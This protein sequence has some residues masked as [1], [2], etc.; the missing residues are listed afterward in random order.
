MLLCAIIVHVM[1]HV[2]L[3]TVKAAIWRSKDGGSTFDDI[4]ERFK[5]Q[6][7]ISWFASLAALWH[8]GAFEAAC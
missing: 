7:S 5:S 8:V 4:S 1:Q 6:S 3:L 2:F